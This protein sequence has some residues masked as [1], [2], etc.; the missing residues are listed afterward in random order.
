MN[1]SNADSY[2]CLDKIVVGQ[3]YITCLL[4]HTALNMARKA[5]SVLPKPTSPHNKRSIGTLESISFKT[6]SIANCWSLVGSYVKS[7][8]KIVSSSK[9]L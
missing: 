8:A 4:L 2:C 7:L 1:L 3:R 6:S 9:S 5:T